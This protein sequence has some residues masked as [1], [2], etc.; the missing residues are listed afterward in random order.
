MKFKV[1]GMFPDFKKKEGYSLILRESSKNIALKIPIS[2]ESANHIISFQKNRIKIK[3]EEE[4]KSRSNIIEMTIMEVYDGFIGE[5]KT[6]ANNKEE[7][8]WVA[9]GN[10]VELSILSNLPI[11]LKADH[12]RFQKD[13]SVII[14]EYNLDGIENMLVVNEESDSLKS[15]VQSLMDAGEYEKLAELRDEI[16][17][18]YLSKILDSFE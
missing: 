12:S 8:S 17:E 6:S 1:Y 11:I 2:N 13:F 14:S 5:V 15:K 10:I 18:V 16:G 9:I 4:S 7:S 3:S